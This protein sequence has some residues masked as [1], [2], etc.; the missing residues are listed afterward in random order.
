MPKKRPPARQRPLARYDGWLSLLAPTKNDPYYR[1]HGT[2]PNGQPIDTTAGRTSER[3]KER[4]TQVAAAYRGE[5]GRLADRQFER[6]IA[7]YLNPLNHTKWGPRRPHDVGT[8]LRNHVPPAVRNTRCRDLTSLHFIQILNATREAG[9][10]P[11]TVQQ[12]GSILRGVITF[13]QRNRYFP[14]GSDPMDGVEYSRSS[15]EDN[16]DAL[17]V[18]IADRPELADAD[19]LGVELAA[20][21]GLWWWELAA[22]LTARCGFRWG[23]LIALRPEDIDTTNRLIH[24]KT[25]LAEHVGGITRRLPKNGKTR[26]VPYPMSLHADIVRRIGEVRV[27]AGET[28]KKSGKSKNPDQLLFCTKEGTAPRRSNFNKRMLTPAREAAGWPAD[29]F[30]VADGTYRQWKWSWH[31]LRHTCASRFWSTQLNGGLG[32]DVADAA[33]L[34]GHSIAVFTG[35]YVQPPKGY[36]DTARERMDAAE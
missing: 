24:V 32:L 6:L 5:G 26:D 18:P 27:A 9:Y 28:F 14:Y 15:S 36:L 34:M 4:A 1:L 17:W 11:N 25:Q 13:G 21:S 22:K 2:A 16:D 31:S 29:V 23:E 8:M 3:A 20:V 35:M 19:R 10:A 12:L 33:R 7:E 30:V